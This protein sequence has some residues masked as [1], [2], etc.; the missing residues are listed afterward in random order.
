MKRQLLV[1]V[2][3][4]SAC[5]APEILSSSAPGA[6][7]ASGN[8]AT[9][10]VLPA[11]CPE[12]AKPIPA[13]DLIL[14]LARRTPLFLA[15]VSDRVETVTVASLAVQTTVDLGHGQSG[16]LWVFSVQDSNANLSELVAQKCPQIGGKPLA[17]GTKIVALT[18]G[19][20][21]F[22]GD[23]LNGRRILKE[24]WLEGQ[25]SRSVVGE[26]EQAQLLLDFAANK[27]LSEAELMERLV[28]EGPDGETA[29]EWK[30]LVVE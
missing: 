2:L 26:L 14:A 22:N 5:R 18:I 12:D 4:I 24:G 17:P 27:G 28:R 11:G 21:P 19:G 20:Q 16:A 6:E 7:T 9:T 23:G 25:P 29:K 13:D 3:F 15:S 10:E 8:L 30:A 1:L